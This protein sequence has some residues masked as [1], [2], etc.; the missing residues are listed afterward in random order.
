VIPNQDF[1]VR[2]LR[3]NAVL[4]WEYRPGSSLFFVWSQQREQ[5]FD[6]ARANVAGQ[7]V[8]TFADPG[9]HVFLIKFSRWIGR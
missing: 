3:G 4:R 9:R 8:R 7:S 1:T 2:A 5:E 6:D